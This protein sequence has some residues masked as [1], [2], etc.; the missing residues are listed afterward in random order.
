MRKPKIYLDTSVISHLDQHDAPEKMSDTLILWEDIKAGAYDIYLSAVALNEILANDNN[1]R[2]VL[3]EYLNGIEYNNVMVDKEVTAYAD[4]LV[5]E[6]ILTRKRYDDC[7]H[8]AC[9]VV[10]ECNYLLSW[11]IRH[12]ARVKTVNGV[13]SINA[14]LGYHGIDIYPPNMFINKE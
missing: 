14:M 6:G 7:L 5:D 9:A 1:K 13:R 8:I 11:N 4:K 10:S 2:L 3:L 12:I